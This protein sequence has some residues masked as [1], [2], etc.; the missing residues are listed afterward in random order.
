MNI[1]KEFKEAVLL[2]D[3]KLKMRYSASKVTLVVFTLIFF[4]NYY[5]VWLGFSLDFFMPSLAFTYMAFIV[6][7]LL[8]LFFAIHIY[9]ENKI[10]RYVWIAILVILYIVSLIIFYL[11]KEIILSLFWL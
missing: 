10:L 5:F 8:Y 7:L 6:S 4:L 3:K 1:I 2:S 9:F 11:P